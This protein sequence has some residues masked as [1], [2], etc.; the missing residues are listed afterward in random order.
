MDLYATGTDEVRVLCVGV[1]ARTRA[2]GSG[3]IVSLAAVRATLKILIY[4]FVFTPCD[5]YP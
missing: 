4:I 1:N 5:S 2:M 3:R